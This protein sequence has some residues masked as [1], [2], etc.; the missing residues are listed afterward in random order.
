MFL[1]FFQALFYFFDESQNIFFNQF[2]INELF[3]TT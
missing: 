2:G 3:L 1:F